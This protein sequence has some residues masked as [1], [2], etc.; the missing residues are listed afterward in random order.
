MES[1]DELLKKLDEFLEDLPNDL[2]PPIP[3]SGMK[4]LESY[5]KVRNSSTVYSIVFTYLN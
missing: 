5:D 3:D 2:L 4:V 1:P